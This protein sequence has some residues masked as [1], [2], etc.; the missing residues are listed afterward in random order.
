MPPLVEFEWEYLGATS[1]DGVGRNDRAE[2]RKL[3]N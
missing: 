2:L 3:R 1:D